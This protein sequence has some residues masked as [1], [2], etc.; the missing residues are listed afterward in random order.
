MDFSIDDKVRINI[1]LDKIRF[2]KAAV[3]S[4]DGVYGK[5]IEISDIDRSARVTIYDKK[6]YL[7]QFDKQL[8]P[9]FKYSSLIKAFWFDEQQIALHY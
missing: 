9:L 7:V 1:S 5:I 2:T 6:K 8:K 3:D 4:L